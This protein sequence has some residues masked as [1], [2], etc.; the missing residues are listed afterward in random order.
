MQNESSKMFKCYIFRTKH[1]NGCDILRRLV[2]NLPLT[3]GFCLIVLWRVHVMYHTQCWI[4]PHSIMNELL[5]IGH[6]QVTSSSLRPSTSVTV[7]NQHLL[8]DIGFWGV[9]ALFTVILLLP[10]FLRFDLQTED[11]DKINISSWD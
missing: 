7:S 1:D 9:F 8:V 5:G 2:L 4:L 10:R 6:H 3:F 11:K